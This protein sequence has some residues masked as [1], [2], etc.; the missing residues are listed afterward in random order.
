MPGAGAGP[1]TAAVSAVGVGVAAVGLEEAA[2]FEADLEFEFVLAEGDLP[3][4]AVP[5]DSTVGCPALDM[6]ASTLPEVAA[7]VGPVVLAVSEA[8][9]GVETAIGIALRHK[10]HFYLD[11][12]AGQDVAVYKQP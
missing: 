9:L 11:W 1:G 6:A 5:W 12:C 8:V 2:G 4:E 10:R 3:V 7:V